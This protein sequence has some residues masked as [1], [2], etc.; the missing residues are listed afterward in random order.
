MA[1][2][3]TITYSGT[4]YELQCDTV[5]H[6]FVRAPT[7]AG[8]PGE[9]SAEPIVITVDLGVVT[10]QISLNG[11]VNTISVG[12]DDP[13]KADLETVCLEWWKYGDDPTTMPVLAIPGGSYYVTLKTASFRMEGALEDRWAFSLAWLV[14]QEI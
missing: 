1:I 9:E 10:Q 11:I 12:G 3:T 5:E 4:T 13:A 6:V 8:M 2:A 7:Q 14:R